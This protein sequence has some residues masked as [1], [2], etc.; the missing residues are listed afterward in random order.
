MPLAA[1]SNMNVHTMTATLYRSI[2]TVRPAMRLELAGS[3]ENLRG[4]LVAPVLVC[5]CRRGSFRYHRVQRP[6]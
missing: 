4:V 1:P 5:E 2:D 6:D 3:E